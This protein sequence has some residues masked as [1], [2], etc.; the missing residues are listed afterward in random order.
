MSTAYVARI[1]EGGYWCLQL[2]GPVYHARSIVYAE[3]V[4][5]DDQLTLALTEQYLYDLAE[6][7]DL[8][9]RPRRRHAS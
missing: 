9:I 3:V 6:A 1:D 4:V 2:I 8:E 7:K 5:P